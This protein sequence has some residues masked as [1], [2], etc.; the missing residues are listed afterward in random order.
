MRCQLHFLTGRAE[1]RLSFD[2]QPQLAERLGYVERGGLT[3]VERF[4]KHYFLIAKDVGD[5]TRIFCAAL[6]AQEMK[7]PPFF[8]QFLNRL[9]GRRTRTI[10]DARDFTLASGRI[11]IIDDDAFDRRD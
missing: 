3:H 1:D 10:R 6:E 7:A 4:M 2:L 9:R 8:S 11:N 5:L